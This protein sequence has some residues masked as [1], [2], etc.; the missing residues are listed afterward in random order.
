[1]MNLQSRHRGN[2]LPLI[3]TYRKNTLLC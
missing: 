1:M 2:S 3:F